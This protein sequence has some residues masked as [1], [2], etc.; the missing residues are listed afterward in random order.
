MSIT[1]NQL[2]ILSQIIKSNRDLYLSSLEFVDRRNLA[3]V[4]NALRSGIS[5]K[6][7]IIAIWGSVRAY[8]FDDVKYYNDI[9]IEIFRRKNT[10]NSYLSQEVYDTLLRIPDLKIEGGQVSKTVERIAN[11]LSAILPHSLPTT[12]F[13]ACPKE[14]KTIDV[15]ISPK[16][17]LSYARKMGKIDK[18]YIILGI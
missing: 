9:G 8:L 2:W 7:I 12:V 15:L 5:P 10:K 4:I 16:D 3:I 14:G 17:F 11:K 18:H 13:T 6:P 1:T